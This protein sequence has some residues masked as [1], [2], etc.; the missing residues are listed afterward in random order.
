M[1][2]NN[3][4]YFQIPTI[5]SIGCLFG[6]LFYYTFQMKVV[7]LKLKCDSHVDY[8]W[9]LFKAKC[10]LASGFLVL[11]ISLLL[12]IYEAIIVQNPAYLTI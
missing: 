8:R 5:I 2:E 3:K 1:E 9:N 6:V 7:L 11:S 12:E 10:V 4:Q